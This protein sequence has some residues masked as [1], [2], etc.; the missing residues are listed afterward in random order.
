ML[1]VWLWLRGAESGATF[2]GRGWTNVQRAFTAI[3]DVIDNAFNFLVKYCLSADRV[4]GGW[5]RCCEESAGEEFKESL[6]SFGS[7]ERVKQV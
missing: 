2:I 5:D 1:I 7:G 3:A 6:L 4:S